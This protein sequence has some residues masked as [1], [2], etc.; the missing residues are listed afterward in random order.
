MLLKGKQDHISVDA[1][2]QKIRKKIDRIDDR[3]GVLLHD[4]MACVQEIGQIKKTG[5]VVIRDQKREDN[6]VDRVAKYAQLDRAF[7]ER[8]FGC[9]FAYSRTIQKRIKK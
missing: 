2:I 9:I 6:I 4:R 3:I 8:V 7:V 1:K 5:G